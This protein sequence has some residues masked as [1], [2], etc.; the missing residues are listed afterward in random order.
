MGA[1]IAIILF[2]TIIG[3]WLLVFRERARE[4]LTQWLERPRAPVYLHAV[5]AILI[6][7]AVFAAWSFARGGL[8]AFAEAAQAPEPLWAPRPAVAELP[9][10]P[11]SREICDRATELKA[12]FSARSIRTTILGYV[13]QSDGTIHDIDVAGSSGNRA[14]DRAV[15]ACVATLRF[16]PPPNGQAMTVEWK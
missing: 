11:S 14:L 6:A 1:S 9:P 16:Q 13:V 8:F 3:A 2:F 4:Q 5:G 12:R 10:T 15:M 7:F